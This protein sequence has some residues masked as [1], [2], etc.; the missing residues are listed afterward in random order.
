VTDTGKKVKSKGSLT[1]CKPEL[2]TALKFTTN[3]IFGKSLNVTSGSNRMIWAIRASSYM[4]IGKDS[5]HEG[6]DGLT[7]TRYRGGGSTFP[8]SIDFTNTTLKNIHPEP[9]TA[10]S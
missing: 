6:C 3:S 10:L 8:W 9:L 7:R 4:H 5:Y 1:C 2:Y